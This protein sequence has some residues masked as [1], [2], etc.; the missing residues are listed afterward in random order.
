M[1]VNYDGLNRDLENR[2]T[3]TT[4][5]EKII[6]AETQ[7]ENI[8]KK[9]IEESNEP[10]LTEAESAT[11]SEYTATKGWVEIVNSAYQQSLSYN[12]VLE[13]AEIGPHENLN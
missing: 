6:I 3:N 10:K 13:W 2:E 8:N 4:Y 1:L 5:I 11:E 9:I 7:P 12:H